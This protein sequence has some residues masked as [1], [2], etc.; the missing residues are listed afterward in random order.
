MKITIEI[1][2]GVTASAIP[3][4]LRMKANKLDG[5]TGK[6]AAKTEAKTEELV[7]DGENIE[8]GDAVVKV[9]G[10]VKKVKAAKKEPE[11]T[12][13]LGFGDD[14]PSDA[15]AEEA[16]EKGPSLE[17]VISGFKA[18]AQKK[19]RD[20]AGKV[21]AKYK[22]KSVNDLPEESY[23]KVLKEIEV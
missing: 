3:G 20:K 7:A 19:G 9:E 11:E 15:D 2:D 1:P 22:V 23:A 13:D 12:F 21:L 8:A 16:E 17:D 5:I 4:L 6:D 10:K 18:F 14:L